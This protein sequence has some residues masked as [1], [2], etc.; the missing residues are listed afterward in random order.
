[1]RGGLLFLAGL[2]VIVGPKVFS[3]GMLKPIESTTFAVESLRPLANCIHMIG[4]SVA[5]PMVLAAPT[6][7]CL[8]NT[9][10]AN[11]SVL[12]ARQHAT[13][14][15]NQVTLADIRGLR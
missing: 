3:S 6:R 1:M 9:F 15:Q 12:N 4:L 14:N 7:I 13:L 10:A 8:V 11:P 5:V 2:L